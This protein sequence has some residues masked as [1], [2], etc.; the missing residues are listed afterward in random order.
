LEID[1]EPGMVLIHGANGQGKSNLIEALYMLAIAKSLRAST[2]KELVRRQSL[3]G[4]SHAHVSAAVQR[5]SGQT[6][7]QVDFKVGNAGS[8]DELDVSEQTPIEAITVQ[9]LVRVNGAPRRASELVGEVNAVVFSAQDLELVFGSPSTRR[10]Y[11]DILISQLD[12]QYLRSVQRYQKVVSQRN[13][14]LKLVRDGRSGAGELEFWDDELVES[15]KYIMFRRASVI[16]TLSEMIAALYGDLSGDGES[17]RL[18]Y[19]PGVQA[20]TEHGEEEFGDALRTALVAARPRELAQGHTVSGPHR[21]DAIVMLGGIPAGP[22]ASRGQS[23]TAV[24]ALKL[25]E[26][27]IL[28]EERDDEPILLLDDVLSELDAGRRAQVLD[29]AQHYQQCFITSADPALVGGRYLSQM[30]R[31]AVRDGAIEAVGE[32]EG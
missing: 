32:S 25:A 10:R 14:L 9:K 18:A 4:D 29:L 23:R 8:Q 28:R 17:L 22:Y 11:L 7:V 26:A 5:R 15:G 21:D 20:P 31:F 13:H 24:L 3:N 2:D 27:S 6:R 1:F 16:K 12:R 30:A 19:R